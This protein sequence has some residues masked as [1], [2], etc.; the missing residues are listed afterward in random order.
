M[1]IRADVYRTIDWSRIGMTSK[2]VHRASGL[3]DQIKRLRPIRSK[4]RIGGIICL[5]DKC[6]PL[7]CPFILTLSR[8]INGGIDD[9]L[10]RGPEAC[11]THGAGDDST[12]E[13][14]RQKHT[15]G[16]HR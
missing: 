1:L 6:P 8:H 14:A 16:N 2:E 11:K 7:R 4:Q 13:Y 5:A 15:L 9:G 12:S 3:I 10:G